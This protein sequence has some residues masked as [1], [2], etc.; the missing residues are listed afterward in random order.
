VT[1][2]I[3]R[4]SHRPLSLRLLFMESSCRRS[5]RGGG[6]PIGS[7]HSGSGERSPK[8]YR[9]SRLVCQQIFAAPAMTLAG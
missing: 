3:S 9:L 8:G 7:N 5:R 2:L 6:N 4:L 1:D